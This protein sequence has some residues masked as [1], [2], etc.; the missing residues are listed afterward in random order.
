[1]LWKTIFFGSMTPTS[2]DSE[3]N[4]SELWK[5]CFLSHLSLMVLALIIYVCIVITYWRFRYKYN[6]KCLLIADV[7]SI[8]SIWISSTYFKCYHSVY[9]VANAID[10]ID[11]LINHKDNF[12]VVCN[13][14]L[15][16]FWWLMIW[17]IIDYVIWTEYGL[18]H[19]FQT[20]PRFVLNILIKTYTFNIKQHINPYI[21][22]IE[23]ISQMILSYNKKALFTKIK[24]NMHSALQYVIIEHILYSIDVIFCVLFGIKIYFEYEDAIWSCSSLVSA[25]IMALLWILLWIVIAIILFCIIALIVGLV[26][27]DPGGLNFPISNA[28]IPYSPVP[29]KEPANGI[30]SPFIII[31]FIIIWILVIRALLNTQTRIDKFETIRAEHDDIDTEDH[32]V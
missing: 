32:I 1:M 15:N 20:I 24:A 28:P 22:D 4:F 2:T 11:A 3:F 6:H 30:E 31:I 8:T 5:Y 27:G 16:S 21:N 14:I 7:L 17:T 12:P 23:G 25:L 26:G 19:L 13:N 9:F 29:S 18:H 10:G